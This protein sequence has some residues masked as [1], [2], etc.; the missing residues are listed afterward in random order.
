MKLKLFYVL[1]YN[2]KGYKNNILG[3][4]GQ[5]SKE[6]TS[7]AVS[8]VSIIVVALVAFLSFKAFG[9]SE[10]KTYDQQFM[11]S[12]EKGLEKRWSQPDKETKAA[13]GKY[14]QAELD[15]VEQY[16]DKNFKNSKL[17]E[18]AIAYINV[19]NESKDELD[20]FGSDEFYEKWDKTYD[21]RTSILVKINKIQKIKVSG[22]KNKSQLDELLGNG[23]SATKKTN[24]TDKL[25]SIL[26]ETS[27]EAQPK[28]YEDDTFTT[29][30][31]AVKNTTGAD[32]SDFTA[33]VK[34]VNNDGV[35]VDSQYIDSEEWLQNETSQFEFMTDK[36]F[37]KTEIRVTYADF[38]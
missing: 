33:T 4:N 9:N 36:D 6:K 11:T 2:T 7:W 29:Y 12:L 32:I 3:S 38:K 34:L 18:Q 31:A 16:K 22:D 15:N 28:D 26:K 10:S 23:K 5:M 20:I 1:R 17:Q 13:Y 8:I 21:D 27:F 24:S 14:I 35:V 37:S 30:R 25:N 19:L